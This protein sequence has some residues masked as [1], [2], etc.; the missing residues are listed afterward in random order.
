MY[1]RIVYISE[2][3]LGFGIIATS[4]PFRFGCCGTIK[5]WRAVTKGPGEVIFQVWR[6]S[7]KKNHYILIGQNRVKCKQLYI[8][9]RRCGMIANEATIYLS[10][11]LVEIS[12]SQFTLFSIE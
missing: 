7:D 4:R 9:I 11:N 8:R 5:K 3:F 10:S 6:H 12:I 2:H 1:T